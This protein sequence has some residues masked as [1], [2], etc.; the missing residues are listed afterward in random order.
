[1]FAHIFLTLLPL[2]ALGNVY[3][4]DRDNQRIRKV[5]FPTGIITTVA[6]S[7]TS[8]SYSGDNGQATSAALNY[9]VRLTVDSSGRA[10]VILLSGSLN[11][12]L[13]GNVYFADYNNHRIRKVTISTG[14]ITTIAG[15]GA[16]SYSGDE[17]QATSATLYYPS[18]VKVDSSGKAAV[19]SN[20]II[21][22]VF[23]RSPT[24]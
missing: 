20:F 11:V 10:H 9:P 16:S 19:V 24:R 21:N 4:A 5:T 15:T 13:L 1:M 17:G 22:S 7:S 23:M 18:G 2:G 6:G 12:L 8:G 14:I 3:I